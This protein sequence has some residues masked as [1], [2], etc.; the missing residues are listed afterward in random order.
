[1]GVK[2]VAKLLNRSPAVVRLYLKTADLPHRRE[3]RVGR[4][5]F[6][7]AEVE[8]WRN[9]PETRAMLAFGDRL[10]GHKPHA[11]A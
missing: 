10:R 1:M 11:V 9:R 4:L 5:V 3:G 6:D 8:E 2:D 7:P